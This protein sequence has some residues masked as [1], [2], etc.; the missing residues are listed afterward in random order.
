MA[1]LAC[2]DSFRP[3]VSQLLSAGM[4]LISLL[5]SLTYLPDYLHLSVNPDK[6]CRWALMLRWRLAAAAL[7]APLLL[8]FPKTIAELAPVM[9]AFGWMITIAI[10]AKTLIPHRFLLFSFWLSDTAL[11]TVLLF[12]F[13]LPS[14]S[15]ALL[16]AMTSCLCIVGS[17]WAHW[18]IIVAITGSVLLAVLGSETTAECVLEI[19]LIWFSTLVGFEGSRRAQKQSGKNACHAMGELM[20]FTSYAGDKITEM[21]ATSN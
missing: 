1:G 15:A 11:I 16:F 17:K 4:I 18:W 10:V 21:W 3:T 2:A 6:V 9:L 5:V 20:Q 12:F 8:R 13:S 14:S 7:V 19:A